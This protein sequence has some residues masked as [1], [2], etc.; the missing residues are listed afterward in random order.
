MLNKDLNLKI[1]LHLS[2][3]TF[4]STFTAIHKEKK[5]SEIFKLDVDVMML[6]QNKCVRIWCK[7]IFLKDDY[8]AE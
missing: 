3:L 2:V 1:N 8:F 7:N 5:S 4:A 6:L